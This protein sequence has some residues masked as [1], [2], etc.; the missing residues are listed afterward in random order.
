MGNQIREDRTFQLRGSMQTGRRLGMVLLDDSLVKLVNE[1]KIEA[2]EAIMR[3]S[4]ADYVIK[5]LSSKPK[6]GS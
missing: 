2:Q 6:K 1:D 5:E 3:A 4:D